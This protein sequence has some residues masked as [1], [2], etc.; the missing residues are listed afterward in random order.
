MNRMDKT[1]FKDSLMKN[2]ENGKHKNWSLLDIYA[3]D[4]SYFNKLRSENRIPKDIL[5][6]FFN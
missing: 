3:D 2:F 6:F 1:E 5:R 4:P